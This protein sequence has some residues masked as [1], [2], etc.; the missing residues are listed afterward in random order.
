MKPKW[1]TRSAGALASAAMLGLVASA[2]HAQAFPSKPINFIV[3]YGP[4]TGNDIIARLISQKVSENWN[5]P[6]VVENK[7]GASGAIGTEAAAKAPA[8][9][10]TLL[11]ASTS[12]LLNPLI[13]KVR[14]DSLKDFAPVAVPGS[15]PYVLAVPEALP[16][17]SIKE[18]V[19]LAKSRP[20]KVNYAGSYGSLSH[21]MGEMLKTAGGID[22]ALIAYK[23][24]PDAVADVLGNRVEI[25]FTTMASAVPL[26]KTGKIRVLATAGKQRASVLPEV[27]TFTEAAFPTLD[28]QAWFYVLAP[29]AT[30]IPVITTLNREITKAL[31]SADVKEKLA[32]AGVEPQNTTPEQAS[33]MLKNEV[34]LWARIVKESGVKME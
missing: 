19:A 7:A 22:I 30:P 20:G 10:H 5:R 14:Y 6:V 21:F 17:K 25:W 11:M 28:V 33:A 16:A 24:T 12:Q 9:G 27:P 1:I 4:G 8:D 26:A 31:A 23:S 18:L 29:A 15:L 13:S 32:V 3:P 2:A 34:A